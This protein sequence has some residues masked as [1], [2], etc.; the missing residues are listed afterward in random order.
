MINYTEKSRRGRPVCRP[1]NTETKYMLLRADTRVRPYAFDFSIINHILV[2][3]LKK[4]PY[5]PCR[6]AVHCLLKC[7]L[8]L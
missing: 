1:G 3:S 8:T 6:Y 2:Q 7:H 4:S 5:S